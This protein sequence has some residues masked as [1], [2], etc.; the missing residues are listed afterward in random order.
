M[1]SI[2]TGHSG[3]LSVPSLAGFATNH[4][5]YYL[6]LWYFVIYSQAHTPTSYLGWSLEKSQYMP[7]C[8]SQMSLSLQSSPICM[9]QLL[10]QP[11]PS[12]TALTPGAHCGRFPHLQGHWQNWRWSATTRPSRGTTYGPWFAVLL[13]H[14]ADT[15]QGHLHH[16]WPGP[17]YY[18]KDS[19]GPWVR[20]VS[21]TQRCERYTCPSPELSVN[22]LCYFLDVY[23]EK[24]SR[25]FCSTCCVPSQP[26]SLKPS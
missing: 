3:A 18:N 5:Q 10:Q 11:H 15:T 1:L 16:L 8:G 23:L 12:S 9:A 13:K 2:C 17:V 14:W 21:K 7:L 4:I 6:L 24:V 25:D 26:N 19:F 20:C 22:G